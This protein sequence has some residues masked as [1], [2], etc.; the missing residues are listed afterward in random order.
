MQSFNEENSAKKSS[1]KYSIFLALFLCA[2]YFIYIHTLPFATWLT[3]D[4]FNITKGNAFGSSLEFFVY[5]TIKI[6]LLLVLMVYLLALCRAGLNTETVRNYL[7]GKKRTLAYGIAALFGSITPF[8][9]CSSIPLFIAFTNSR[10]PLGIT[11]SFLITSPLINEVAIILLWGILGWKLTLVYIFAGLFSGIIGGF[12]IDSLKAERWLQ[13]FLQKQSLPMGFMPTVKLKPTLS[14]RHAFA[15]KETRDI[16]KKVWLWVLIGVGIG[17]ILHGYVP[18]EWFE[19]HFS[20]SNWWTV[21]FSVI[22]GIPLYTGVT[23]IVPIMESLLLKGVPL[24]TT[25]AFCMSAVG[26]SLPE[27]LLLKQVMQTKLLVIFI[28]LLLV[29]F[30]F[31]GYFLNF[32]S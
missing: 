7:I 20:A 3:Y 16:V 6:L 8:C 15:Y 18:Q 24:G 30:T 25:L 9:S 29:L 2:W 21:P 13:P 17:A 19:R 27:L 5:D 28:L 1:F 12:I 11:M 14:Q 31:I 4:L 26:A 23:G 22:A 10:I 32:I